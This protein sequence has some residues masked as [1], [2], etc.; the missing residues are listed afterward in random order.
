MNNSVQHISFINLSTNFL[1]TIVYHARNTFTELECSIVAF[2]F[3][4]I[5]Q[6]PKYLCDLFSNK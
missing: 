5:K 2:G 1:S 4:E 6:E 3:G